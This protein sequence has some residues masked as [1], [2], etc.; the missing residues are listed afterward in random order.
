MLDSHLAQNTSDIESLRPG[1]FIS[2]PTVMILSRYNIADVARVLFSAVF[3]TALYR[4]LDSLS[5]SFHETEHKPEHMAQIISRWMVPL[6]KFIL[7]VF[8]LL[9]F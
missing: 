6:Q 9:F 8:L 5:C 7:S 3:R 1:H 2:T 4:I